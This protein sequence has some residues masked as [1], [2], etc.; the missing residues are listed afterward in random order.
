MSKLLILIDGSALAYRSFFAFIRNPLINSHGENTGAV[1]GFTN[2][3]I[4]LLD[5][6]KPDY[7]ACVFDTPAPTF[8]H[9]LY[10]EY[11]S[12][13]AKMPDELAESLSWIKDVIRCFN[14][15]VI[16]MEGFEADDIIGTLAKKA[17]KKD[18]E[19]GMFTGDKDFYQLVDDKIKLLH[20]KTME[21]FDSKH[22]EEKLG[23]PP[24]RVIDLL[25]LMGDTSD[26]VPG[27]RGV[28]EKTAV[29]LLNEFGDFDT[30]L[31][32]ADKVKQ[33]KIS[34]SLK[35]NA[36]IARLSYKL[37]TI[38][39]HVPVELDTQ[40]LVVEPPDKTKLA[41]LF[42][43]LEFGTLYKKYAEPESSQEQ[44]GLDF[45]E[46][47]NYTTVKSLN[48]LEDILKKAGKAGELSLDT[49]TTSKNALEAD[50][51]GVS[52]AYQEG[53]AYYVPLA[54]AD[55]EENLAFDEALNIFKKF[56]D[57]KIRII[58]HNIKYDR[59]VFDNYGLAVN[60]IYFDTMIASYLIDPGKRSH[61]LDYLSDEYLQYKMQPITDL[62][63]TGKKQISFA[64]VPVDKATFYSGEDADIALK[65]K[66]HLA[67]ILKQNKLEKLFFEL[68]MPLLSVLGDMEKHGVAI[69]NDF[70]KELSADYGR[71]MKEIE[72]D[73]YEEAGQEFNI[74][75]PDQLRVILFDKLQLPSS[76]KTAKGGK[77]STDVGVLE[78]LALIHPLPKM[79]L[80]Y[81]QLMKLKSTYIDA[82]PGLISKKT[83]RVHTSF[84]QTIAA[85]GRLSSSDPNLQNIPIRTELG[86]EIRKAF[87]AREGFDILSADYSQIELRLM[88]HFAGDKALIESFRKGE[89]IHR[90]TAAEVFG[91]K[92]EDVTDD[93]RR[94]AK[95]A[96]FAIIYG[97]SAYGLSM[98]SELSVR[99]AQ[100]YISAY[101]AR[102]PGVKKYMD[103]M[104]AFAREKGY[105]ETLLKRRRYLPDI[106][107]KSR[108]AREFAERTAINTP[109]Q[110]TAADLIKLAMI[111]ISHELK[112]KKSWMI[113]Q[114]HDELV[115][116]QNLKEKSFLQ[117]MVRDQ[118]ENALKLNVP[119]KVD[120]GEGSNWLEAH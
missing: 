28:G 20:P 69:D 38:D 110:G 118:M 107:A 47:Y 98:Q 78:K 49:E 6:I 68:E 103:D 14:I 12:T 50:L 32:S 100:D 39:C 11:K 99:E 66:G 41:E 84:N 108:Q 96:N 89:D 92:L 8:R 120:L 72:K 46:S 48:E 76:R 26:N 64:K 67:T 45:S 54:H 10:D 83:G 31:K 102:Y 24:E 80:G 85:T 116:E 74:N 87:I 7:I 22:V 36:D 111:N 35:E 37:V 1:F 57:S 9:E 44:I 53:Q 70:L 33:K 94:S 101:F 113:L 106:A 75:S 104:K 23:V 73:I 90:R 63:G 117:N 30:V 114:V 43:R 13:R 51:V 55:K 40:T 105:V 2:S 115:F 5:E 58:G 29:K 52:L 77:K 34:E 25:A 4:K 27:V 112:G 21:W 97:V 93:Q 81:R 18:I 119:I 82:I 60:E 17:A 95:T 19:V 109:I 15:P 91:V 61:K 42:K 71:R 79:I 16:E 3:L 59:Q 62:I 86:R 65:L 88:A 56:F